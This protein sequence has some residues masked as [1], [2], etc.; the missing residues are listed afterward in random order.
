MPV[1]LLH[2][3]AKPA[4]P[5]KQVDECKCTVG[6][7]DQPTWHILEICRKGMAWR[8]NVSIHAQLAQISRK[9]ISGDRLRRIVIFRRVKHP[10]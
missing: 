10:V 1:L 5:C 2:C 9:K 8:R 7:G 4:N 3:H 6:I